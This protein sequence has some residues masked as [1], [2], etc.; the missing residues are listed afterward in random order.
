MICGAWAPSRKDGLEAVTNASQ[1][2]SNMPVE[3]MEAEHPVRVEEYAFV[4]DTGGAG[5]W[6]GGIGLR[7]SYRI[8]AP[9]ALLQLRTDRV[10]FQPY[11]L[12]GGEPGGRSQNFIEI[13][14]R[15]E[16]LPGKVTMTVPHDA[17][18]VHEQ[19]GGGGFGDPVARDPALV[20]EDVLDGKI[21][22]EFAQ[23]HYGVG[24]DGGRGTVMPAAGEAPSAGGGGKAIG[25]A[26][27]TA[28][29]RQVPTGQ[30]AM[31]SAPGRRISRR[32]LTASATS[33]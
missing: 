8:L 2:L 12:Q 10:V 33:T 22:P 9:E 7:R 21:T 29:A 5:K 4:P 28:M 11:G 6:R 23:R 18:I 3:V 1:N 20:R 24:A 14:N 27:M 19:A 31:A 13:G 17:L 26:P 32:P 15:R 30:R 25:V 16:P